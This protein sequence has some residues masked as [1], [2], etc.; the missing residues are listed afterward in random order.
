MQ[1]LGANSPGLG[2]QVAVEKLFDRCQ[3]VLVVDLELCDG[4]AV[5]DQA[6]EDIQVVRVAGE[7]VRVSSSN[8][9]LPVLGNSAQRSR[10]VI[11]N[12]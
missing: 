1:A 12:S 6:K 4:G 10:E 7:Q 5:V 9:L 11:L 3:D 8:K 2:N